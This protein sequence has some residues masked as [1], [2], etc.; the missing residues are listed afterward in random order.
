M[1]LLKV[2][3]VGKAGGSGDFYWEMSKVVSYSGLR[4]LVCVGEKVGLEDSKVLSG[5]DFS[6]DCV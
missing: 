6:S 1:L 3:D 5:F 2:N 4:K